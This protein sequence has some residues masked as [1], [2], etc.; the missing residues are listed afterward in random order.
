MPEY[1]RPFAPGGTYFLTLVT[2]HRRPFLT[3]A[4]ART[5]LRQSLTD[6][7]GRRPFGLDGVVLLPDHLHLM[8]TLPFADADVSNR[9]AAIKAGFTRRYEAGHEAG[10]GL[11]SAPRDRQSASRDR[12]RYRPIWQKRFHDHLIR[13]D[14][15]RDDHLDYLVYNPVRHGLATCPHAWPYSSFARLVRAGRYDARWSCRC[16]GRRVRPVPKPFSSPEE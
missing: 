7:R 13:D 5:A 6:C 1:R 11:R 4:P 16:D 14:R 10:G 2:H 8:L 12:Q 15:D 9:V 3:D